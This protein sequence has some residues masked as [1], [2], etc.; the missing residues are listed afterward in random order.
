MAPSVLVPIALFAAAVGIVATLRQL[1]AQGAM[2]IRSGAC[3]ACGRYGP[4]EAVD[5][6]QNTGMLYARTSRS[7]AGTLCRR[8]STGAFLRMTGHTAVLGWWGVI[9][10]VVTPVFI[11]NNLAYF[12]RSQT[13]PGFA[14]VH[15]RALEEQRDYAL[16]LLA[17]K[18]R[19]VVVDV[20][21]R[22]TGAPPAE[23]SAWLV[24]VARNAARGVEGPPAAAD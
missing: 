16:A 13:L 6:R 17:T 15:T 20:L 23:V 18:E 22:Q 5:Y 3:E 8:C 9:S 14:A 21:A 7:L 24:A 19:D 1:R 10:C 11:L 4:I 12:L 2:R